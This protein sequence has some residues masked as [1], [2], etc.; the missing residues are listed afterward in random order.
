MLHRR[1]FCESQ[2]PSARGAWPFWHGQ[3]A[4]RESPKD[5][6]TIPTIVAKNFEKSLSA[7]PPTD[8]ASRKAASSPGNE[9]TAAFV[10]LWWD[11]PRIHLYGGF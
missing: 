11:Y 5:G 10:V 3:N 9:S 6:C 2:K 4:G 7:V 8:P 1:I